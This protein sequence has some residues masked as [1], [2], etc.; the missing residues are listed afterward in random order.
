[1]TLPEKLEL[2][3]ALWDDLSKKPE[4]F[5]SP[6]WHAEALQEIQRRVDAGEEKLTDWETVKEELRR[7]TSWK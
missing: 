6:A 3:E 1:M 2:M 7:R 4:E 5:E